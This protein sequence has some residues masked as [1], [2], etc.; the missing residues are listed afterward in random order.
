MCLNKALKCLGIQF[1]REESGEVLL[2]S[3]VK[4]NKKYLVQ[5]KYKV[6]FAGEGVWMTTSR[7]KHLATHGLDST[8]LN[9]L[10]RRIGDICGVYTCSCN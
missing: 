3:S 10:E 1:K 9:V 2:E 4:D 8:L 6:E 5:G 7:N